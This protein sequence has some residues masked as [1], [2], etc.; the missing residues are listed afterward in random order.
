MKLATDLKNNN[1]NISHWILWKHIFSNTLISLYELYWSLEIKK[2]NIINQSGVGC[3]NYSLYTCA[4]HIIVQNIK[5][6]VVFIFGNF[7][8]FKKLKN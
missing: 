2:S 8:Y 6:K 4:S 5:F 3:I 7:I 1:N